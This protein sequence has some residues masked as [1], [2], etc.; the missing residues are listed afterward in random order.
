MKRQTGAVKLIILFFILLYFQIILLL[1]LNNSKS[2]Y[3]VYSVSIEDIIEKSAIVL[4]LITVFALFSVHKIF[5]KL[6]EDIEHKIK[7]ASL[8]SMNEV[9]YAFKAQR[10]DFIKHL[11]CIYS[12]LSQGHLEKSKEYIKGISSEIKDLGPPIN[13]DNLWISALLQSKMS[14]AQSQNT[15]ITFEIRGKLHRFHLSPWETSKVFGNL[16]DNS[17]EAVET[18]PESDRNV[19]VYIGEDRQQ[20]IFRISNPGDPISEE[21]KSL[22]FKRGYSTKAGEGLGLNIV[23]TITESYNGT[24]TIKSQEELTSFEIKI[25][26]RG[27]RDK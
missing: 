11:S 1:S 27:K 8:D 23:K 25:P 9:L 21:E 3:F 17:L 2:G 15:N 16:I 13:C 7:E 22:I 24:V 19:L 20:Y 6:Q 18:L 4:L 26:K 5:N 10:H 12:L 14:K